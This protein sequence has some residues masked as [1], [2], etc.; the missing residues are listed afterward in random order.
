LATLILALLLLT[1]TLAYSRGAVIAFAVV[2]AIMVGAGP[3]R[4]T[5]LAVAA[6]A[7]LSVA[8]AMLVAFS[9]HDLSAS[10]VPLSDRITGG[11]VL[12]GVLALCLGGLGLATYELVRLERRVSWGPDRAR[13]TWICLA[14]CAAVALCIGVVLLATSQRGLGGE[15]SHQID[16]FKNPGSSLSN[17]PERLISANS[18]NRYVWWEEALGAFSD[19]PLAGWGAG[20]FPVIQAL[21]RHQEAPVRSSHS[22]PL[23]LLSETGLVGFAL[24]MGALALL[25]AAA[26]GR[27]R[28]ARGVERSARLALLAAFAAWFVE[29]LFDWHWEI[30]GVTAPALIA[31]AVAAAVPVRRA[32]RDRPRDGWRFRLAV[33]GAALAALAVAALAYLPVLSEQKRLDAL[34]EAGGRPR[35]LAAAADDASLAHRLDPFAVEPLF[36][37]ASI[38]QARGQ[39]RHAFE[40]L[41]D[42]TATQPDNSKTWAELAQRTTNP[43]DAAMAAEEQARTDPLSFTDIGPVVSSASFSRLHPSAASP[44]AF[45]TPPP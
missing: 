16:N 14:A 10:G 36:T 42:A 25:A 23:A 39:T 33:A 26:I 40:L 11:L 20:S 32:A 6:G 24:C 17:N 13:R 5:R 35:D 15:I 9:R 27:V 1:A 8:P 30:P 34:A 12:A 4:L 37:A 7:L 44:T 38:A 19:R 45:G 3:R 41:A 2:L 43:H 31:V 28:S 18:S 22:L 29:S 21:Y